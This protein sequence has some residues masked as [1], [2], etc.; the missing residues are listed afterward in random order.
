MRTLALLFSLF[1]LLPVAE[2]ALLLKVGGILGFWTT[3]GLVLLTGFGGAALARREGVRTL[4]G[5]QGALARGEIPGT[6]LLDGACIL[7]GG[8]LLL[9]PGFLT[10]G[11]G[12]ALLFLPSRRLLQLWLR[13]RIRRGL[14]AGTLRVGVMGSGGGFGWSTA[15]WGRGSSA[16]GNGWGVPADPYRD[17]P[18]AEVVEPDPPLVPP[19]R[20]P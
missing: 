15:T 5:V 8:T 2:L 11:V 14:E 6:S 16:G 4:A 20:R 7:V 18:R 19:T 13:R 3:L 1:V 10:D 9:T 17:I 12:F